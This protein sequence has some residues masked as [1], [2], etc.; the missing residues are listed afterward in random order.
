MDIFNDLFGNDK[1]KN[2]QALGFFAFLEELEKQEKIN[3]LEQEIEKDEVEKNELIDE[4][5]ED[6]KKEDSKDEQ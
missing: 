1:N 3:Q 4:C 2:G 5:G 6:T